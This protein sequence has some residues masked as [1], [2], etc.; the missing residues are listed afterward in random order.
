[1]DQGP[2]PRVTFYTPTEPPDHH[3]QPVT[4][5]TITLDKRLIVRRPTTFW[6]DVRG[7]SNPFYGSDGRLYVR[8]CFESDWYDMRHGKAPR[9]D[10]VPA[11]L[12]W[13]Q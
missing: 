7:L 5:G 13:L 12:V 4:E 10:D 2:F 6:Y 3:V 11:Y 8:A 1:M 9:C